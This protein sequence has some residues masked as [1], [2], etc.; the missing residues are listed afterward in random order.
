MKFTLLLAMS[1]LL[2]TA[3]NTETS[4][5]STTLRD[6]DTNTTTGP[7]TAEDAARVTNKPVLDDTV[8]DPVN[9]TDDTDQIT[10]DRDNSGRNE[11]DKDD[12]TKTPIDQNENK[13]DIDVTATIRK[14]IIDADLSVN[15]SNVKIMTQDGK[16]TLRGVVENDAEKQRIEQLAKQAAGDTNVDNQL[17]VNRP[18]ADPAGNVLP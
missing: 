17:E 9:T 8:L 2:L 1:A 5:N 7:M 4:N 10:H 13:A 14:Q 6:P 12:V 3:C 11:R 15:A 18:A 16:V